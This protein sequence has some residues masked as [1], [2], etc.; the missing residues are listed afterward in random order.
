[1]RAQSMND[2]TPPDSIQ[3]IAKKLQGQVP[4]SKYPKESQHP[5]SK[6]PQKQE[7]RIRNS[8]SQGDSLGLLPPETIHNKN[9]KRNDQA[10]DYKASPT[11]NQ[12]KVRIAP[13]VKVR[14]GSHDSVREDNQ[15]TRGRTLDGKPKMSNVRQAHAGEAA[16]GLLMMRQDDKMKN[17]LP[18]NPPPGK[19]MTNAF[20]RLG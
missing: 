14:R 10:P 8:R 19:R 12:R 16:G 4:I 18:V 17:T 6:E 11:I 1:M 3:L 7:Y 15:A 5:L 13:Q 20:K 2:S 9:K